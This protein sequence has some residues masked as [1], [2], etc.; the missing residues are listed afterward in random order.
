MSPCAVTHPLASIPLPSHRIASP[1]GCHSRRAARRRSSAALHCAP[2]GRC[3]ASSH[4]PPLA[5][6]APCEHSNARN[7]ST[8]SGGLSRQAPQK[9]LGKGSSNLSASLQ[10]DRKKTRARHSPQIKMHYRRVR[11][12]RLRLRTLYGAA[13]ETKEELQLCLHES[14]AD[15]KL[16]AFKQLRRIHTSLTCVSFNFQLHCV[17]LGPSNR[18]PRKKSCFGSPRKS[19]CAARRRHSPIRRCSFLARPPHD[20]PLARGCR[21]GRTPTGHHRQRRAERRSRRPTPR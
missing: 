4:S 19:L 13:L 2:L 3:A 5:P 17:T 10:H 7:R 6:L 15:M 12:L 1:R 16:Q 18:H 9:R 14:L 11:V 20:S 21:S 8:E